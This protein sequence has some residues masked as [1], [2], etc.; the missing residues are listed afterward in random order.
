MESQTESSASGLDTLLLVVALLLLV[1]GMFAFYYFQR[2]FGLLPRI[3]ILAAAT[4]AAVVLGARTAVGRLVWSYLVGARIEMRKVVWP[5]RQE[6]V[7]VT[8]F[9]AGLVLIMALFL[10]GVDSLLLFGVHH[11]S[12]GAA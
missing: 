8:L 3:G 12:G 2:Q 4:A 1:G 11:L 7:Q 6:S 5:S 9:V 10:W